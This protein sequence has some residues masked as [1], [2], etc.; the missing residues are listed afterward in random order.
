MKKYILLPVLAS[1]AMVGFAQDFDTDPTVK[2]DN[3]KEDLHFTVGA[4]MMADVAYYHSDFTP[5]KS[6]AALSDA[7]LRTSLQYKDWYFYADFGFGGGKFSQKNIFVQYSKDA[8]EGTHSVKAG[9]YNDPAGSMARNTSLGSYHFISRPGSSNALGEGREL[10]ITYKFHNNTWFAQQGVFC[11][12][13]YNSQDVGFNG[14]TAAGRWLYRP[15]N[16]DK[17]TLHIGLNARYA[18]IGGGEMENN[19]LKKTLSLG[20]SL[21]TYVDD[22]EQFVSCDIPWAKSTVD[23]G[24]EA[25]YKNEKFFARGEYMFKYV[26]KERDSERLFTDAQ[27][28]I[29]AWGS[30]DAWIGANPL[31]D[32]KFHGGY[33]EAGYLIFGKPYKYNTAEGLLGGLGAKSLEVVARY[34]YTGLNNL[35]DGEYYSAGRAQYYPAGYMQDYPY[36]SAAISGGNVHSVTVGANYAFNKF[37]AVMLNYTYHQLDRDKY[38]YDDNFHS[39][40]ARLMFQF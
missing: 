31:K 28:N 16:D 33:V 10:G 26:A 24:V 37:C 17:Q 20:Q 40:Q 19:V 27:N 1:V 12:D 34:N 35:I 9:Y 14:V 29:D 4:R 3:E 5:M 6:G 13:K 25:L 11:E 38:G 18:H 2:I 15:V 32:N 22:T 36:K 21:E 7:R 30:L 8:K 39:L 23:L